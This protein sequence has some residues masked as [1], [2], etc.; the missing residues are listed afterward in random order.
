MRTRS[1]LTAL[2]AAALLLS[3]CDKD[4]T[5]PA[6]TYATPAKVESSVAPAAAAGDTSVPPA[7]SVLTSAPATPQPASAARTNNDL[8]R[9]QESTAM[10]LAGQ[11]NDHSA[12]LAAGK[13][14]STPR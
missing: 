12:P 13:A 4:R 2:C 5:D 7:A 6:M 10:P 3:A 11:S 14:A 8:T 1:T 9:A